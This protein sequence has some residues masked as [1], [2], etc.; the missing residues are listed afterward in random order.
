MA[1]WLRLS[2]V[3]FVDQV[4]GTGKRVL[5]FLFAT[6][7][8]AKARGVSFV[9]KVSDGKVMSYVPEKDFGLKVTVMNHPRSHAGSDQNN[10]VP[11]V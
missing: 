7:M 9:A 6:G 11:F 3:V 2:L 1:L 5:F 4:L 10:I 8:G